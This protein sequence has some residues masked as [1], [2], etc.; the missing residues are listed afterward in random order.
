MA[1]PSV[2]LMQVKTINEEVAGLLAVPHGGTDS[3]GWLFQDALLIPPA[4]TDQQ[5]GA[6]IRTL[7]TPESG[8]PDA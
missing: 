7:T 8:G 3:M 1:N 4:A 6:H 5:L 2:M